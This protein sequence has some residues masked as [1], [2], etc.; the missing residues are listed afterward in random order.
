MQSRFFELLINRK[1]VFIIIVLAFGFCASYEVLAGTKHDA[2]NKSNEKSELYNPETTP[3]C[4]MDEFSNFE[5]CYSTEKGLVS[6]DLKSVYKKIKKRFSTKLLKSL[7]K[8]EPKDN[9]GANPSYQCAERKL[10]VQ[11]T[12]NSCAFVELFWLFNVEPQSASDFNYAL[13][14][15]IANGVDSYDDFELSVMKYLV[16][17]SNSKKYSDFYYESKIDACQNDSEYV[18]D[19]FIRR[20]NDKSLFESLPH[21]PIRQC[22]IKGQNVLWLGNLKSKEWIKIPGKTAIRI[23]ENIN[24]GKEELIFS[25]SELAPFLR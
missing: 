16:G 17:L 3:A 18:S 22:K 6:E 7:S 13:I 20:I 1:N 11:D 8:A 21:V 25:D 9:Y 23:L 24:D 15:I 10:C 2:C 12:I 19:I 5:N 4:W 14:D